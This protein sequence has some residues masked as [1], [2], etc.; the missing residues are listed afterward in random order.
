MILSK[1]PY[2]EDIEHEVRQNFTTC[3]YCFKEI[4]TKNNIQNL[5]I[6]ILYMY[7]FCRSYV[8]RISLVHD[9]YHSETLQGAL[10]NNT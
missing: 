3:L 8:C 2:E 6:C 5:N 1:S 10:G 9:W 7:I 4:I